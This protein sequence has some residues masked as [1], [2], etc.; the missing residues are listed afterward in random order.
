MK[1]EVSTLMGEYFTMPDGQVLQKM[2]NGEWVSIE[3]RLKDAEV[4][5]TDRFAGTDTVPS[6]WAG[7]KSE[8]V[9]RKKLRHIDDVIKISKTHAHLHAHLIEI[10]GSPTEIIRNKELRR[11]I[12]QKTINDYHIR[13]SAEQIIK[14]LNCEPWNTVL[15]IMNG[16]INA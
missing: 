1:E 15:Q 8:N 5:I 2:S 13:R 12:K 9:T 14:A 7:P 16:E 10:L 11:T 4:S 3:K 6:D